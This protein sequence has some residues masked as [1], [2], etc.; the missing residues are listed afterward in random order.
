MGKTVHFLC[1]HSPETDQ[2]SVA[3]NSGG[4]LNP[5]VTLGIALAG[6]I[7]KHMAAAYVL[8]QILGGLI[9]AVLVRVSCHL[10]ILP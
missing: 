7:T 3:V 1:V 6:A 10:R 9:G 4:H 8:A 2:S 5:A